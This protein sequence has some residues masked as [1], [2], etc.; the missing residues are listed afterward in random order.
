MLPPQGSFGRPRAVSEKARKVRGGVRFTDS[1]PPEWTGVAGR[2]GALVSRAASSTAMAEGLVYARDGQTRECL[3]APGAIEARVQGRRYQAYRVRIALPVFGEAQW[4][5]VSEALADQSSHSAALL[6]GQ[7]P[8]ELITLFDGLGLAL[9]PP[10][11]GDLTVSCEC[12][13]SVS[14]PG[15]EGRVEGSAPGAVGGGGGGGWCK[16]AVCA[17]LIAG[18]ELASR[19]TAVMRLRGLGAEELL[20]RLREKRSGTRVAPTPGGVASVLGAAEARVEPLEACVDRFWD[21]GEELESISTP[22]R[23]PEVRHALLRRLGPSPFEGSRF[24]VVGLLATCY[25]LLS[26][27]AI[28]G[29]V[30]AGR[31]DKNSV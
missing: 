4:R 16:H 23:K 20:E 25:D 2:W 8:E 5:V 28:A 18:Q 26:E 6:T 29:E 19:P 27:R 17:A 22:I 11:V 10:I 21:A 30:S 31:T 12:G 7:V 14:P 15:P 1:W 9:L 13:V 24:P 3:L